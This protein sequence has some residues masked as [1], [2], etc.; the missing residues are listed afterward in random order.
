M[1]I[2]GVLLWHANSKGTKYFSESIDIDVSVLGNGSAVDVSDS[3]ADC[4]WAA[5]SV[6]LISSAQTMIN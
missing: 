6:L 1:T 3:A 2:L 5:C 4:S